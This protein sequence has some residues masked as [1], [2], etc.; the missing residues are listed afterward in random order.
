MTHAIVSGLIGVGGDEPTPVTRH[1]LAMT[2]KLGV[3]YCLMRLGIII[4]KE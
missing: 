4:L 2:I 1:S 3:T